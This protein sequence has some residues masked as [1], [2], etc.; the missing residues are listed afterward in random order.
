MSEEQMRLLLDSTAEGIY[1]IDLHGVCN[2][3]N[4]SAIRLLGYSSAEQLIG[5]KIHELIHHSSPNGA[6]FPVEEDSG[7][8]TFD[9][10]AGKYREDEIFRRADGNSFPAEYWSY[11]Q[12][13]DGELLGWVVTFHDISARKRRETELATALQSV[14]F[15][16][17]M[18]R[19]ITESANDAI[20]MIDPQ[21]NISYWNP[22]AERILGY[23]SEEALGKNLHKLVVPERYISRHLDAFPGFL[24]TGTGNALGKILDWV[25]LRK[26]G[27]EIFV[28]VSLAAVKLNNEWH[29]VGILNDISS[30]KIME[31]TLKKLSTA[32]EFS[33]VS[34]LITDRDGTIEYVNPKFCQQTGYSAGEAIGQNPRILKSG[35]QSGEFYQQMWE[36]IL[37]GE[38]WHGEI[39]NRNKDGVLVWESAAIS[40]ILDGD[41]I[42]THFVGI[43][44]QIEQQKQLMV[45]LTSVAQLEKL[46]RNRAEQANRAKS[47]FLASM[48]HEIR[49]PLNAILGMS[50]LLNES[51]LNEEQSKYLKVICSAGDT[52][53]FLINDILDFSKI[54]AGMLC[55]TPEPFTLTNC[56]KQLE[57]LMSMKASVKGLTLTSSIDSNAP[58]RLVGDSLRL[59]QILI[60]VVGNAIKFTEQG[61]VNL[62]IE[63]ASSSSNE[64]T[65]KFL[66]TDT[67]IGIASDK[68]PIIFESFTQA[69][70][71]TTRNY[72]G[73]GLG[74]AISKRLIELMGGEIGVESEP[75]HGSC[76]H[77]TCSF[78][79]LPL[80]PEESP[81]ATAADKRPVRVLSILLADDNRDNLTVLKAYF[82]KTDHYI[83]T[84]VNGEE[85]VAKVK[86]N[87][88]DMVFMDMEM[89]V[90]D[91]YTAVSLI[92]E[93]EMETGKTPLPIIALTANALLEDH[94]RS[95]DAGC[96]AHLTKPIRKEKLLGVVNEFAMNMRSQ[97]PV[98]LRVES[99]I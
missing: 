53:S 20:L 8:K 27:K 88:Y 71:T 52:L 50:D 51:G 69:D 26:D 90:M 99:S 82:R 44:E 33:P 77:F 45:D 57:D 58:D 38:E 75:G 98:S 93:W 41:G 95:L 67:G 3:I 24:Q 6:R 61:C 21:G 59:R 46:A 43:R 92:R 54:E 64:V 74:L 63:L 10:S 55:L 4:A 87:N 70:R 48:S 14:V 86:E 76:F 80:I 31:N 68:L 85:A 34:I 66:V 16:E 91:G 15:S 28:N 32:V 81:L 13:L 72:G 83:E 37:A 73:S 84:A 36:T 60:N 22:A 12:K 39:R 79:A 96:T 56:V 5:K 18:L 30:R 62:R 40:P 94:Q 1:G 49:T 78:A 65:L 7:C 89:P 25:A 42:V 9:D 23:T 19:T 97:H 29:A 11:P 47:D 2:F 35:E 17:K